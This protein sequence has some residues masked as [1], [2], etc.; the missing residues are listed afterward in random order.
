M[1]KESSYK[2]DAFIGD[3]LVVRAAVYEYPNSEYPIGATFHINDGYDGIDV[4]VNREEDLEVVEQLIDAL[5]D[6]S[7]AI[8]AALS[9]I[10]AE[11]GAAAGAD[12]VN[13]E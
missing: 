1:S 4:D 5:V 9:A 8:K 6:Y 13:E 11:R 7:L 12:G 2:N 3:S 10:T